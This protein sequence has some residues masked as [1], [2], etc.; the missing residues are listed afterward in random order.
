MIIKSLR[1]LVSFLLVFTVLLVSCGGKKAEE[2]ITTG[3]DEKESVSSQQD[4]AIPEYETID[5]PFP[6]PRGVDVECGS[7]TVPEDRSQPDGNKVKIKFAIFR[8]NASNPKPDPIVYLAGGPGEHALESASLVFETRF[9]PLTAN[10][11]LII[12]D[13]R[14]TGYSEPS[15]EC[16][17][18]IELAYEV[19]DQELESGESIALESEATRECYERLKGQGINLS[20]YNSVE[21]AADL[22]DLRLAL[23]YDKWNLFGISYG[24]RL[25]LT[26]MRDYPE[27][28]RSVI[29]NSTVPLQADLYAEMP[30]TFDRALSVLFDTCADDPAADKAYPQLEKALFDTIDQLNDSPA[31]FTVIHPLKGKSYDVLM[32]GDNFFNFIISTLYST[33]II[34]LVP[35]VI[36]DTRDGKYDT[37]ALLVGSNLL[38]IE[39]R[40][41]GMYYSVQCSEELPFSNPEALS[42]ALENYPEIKDYLE[43]SL[44]E[45]LFNICDYWT[46][47][48]PD[49]VE[50]EPVSSDIPTLILAGEFDPITPPSWGK[51]VSETLT[52]SYFF[53]FAGLGHDVLMS[54]E[55][56][57]LDIAL[58]FLDNPL[59][60]PDRTCVLYTESPDFIVLDVNM[61]PFTSTMFGIEGI[62][63]ENWIELTPGAYTRSRLGITAIVQQAV[64]GMDPDALLGMLNDTFEL[65]ETPDKITERTAG[66]LEW[67]I[68][69]QEVHEMIFDIA[70]AEG[71]G[72]TYL[73]FFT[74]IPDDHAFYY[75][76]LLMPAIDAFSPK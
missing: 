55:R 4:Y 41:T 10:R 62:Y 46:E 60:E 22:N 21:S 67:A 18:L 73:I 65:D 76:E 51:L 17:E 49:P 39:L 56:C 42:T 35:K 37:L 50:N 5:C 32:T 14:G 69:Q 71:E 58:E 33:E 24:T 20:A 34:P 19:L 29:L 26:A 7:L 61:V 66:G 44:G 38:N 23:G 63:P 57:P 74:C 53:E 28:I 8:S 11:D 9:A 64:P 16:P 45:Y 75:D 54:G 25:A 59:E 3:Q 72:I 47:T 36:F 48:T 40:S 31:E 1:L 70:L 43:D 15:L 30:S 27:G 6:V 68:Y 2:K 13:Q 12:F 52:D